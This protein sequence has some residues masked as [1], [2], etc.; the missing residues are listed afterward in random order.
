MPEKI[1]DG[2]YFHHRLYREACLPYQETYLKDLTRLGRD[3]SKC[4]LVDNSPHTF[5]F[6]LDNGIPI[7]TWLEDPTDQELPVLAHFL[8][9]SLLSVEDVRPILRDTYGCREKVENAAAVAAMD[10]LLLEAPDSTDGGPRR[11]HGRRSLLITP[12]AEAKE[13]EVEC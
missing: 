5:A 3:L 4:V 9:S 2:K 11:R 12:P 8:Q 10:K 13:L 1:K 7:K 6:Q